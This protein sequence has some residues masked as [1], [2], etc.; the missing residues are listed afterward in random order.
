MFQNGYVLYKDDRGVHA[1]WDS[2]FC[3]RY[4]K[5]LQQVETKDKHVYPRDEIEI[6]SVHR[7]PITGYCDRNSM[8]TYHLV[9]N[10]SNISKSYC[11]NQVFGFAM[12]ASGSYGNRLTTEKGKQELFE[13]MYE[14]LYASYE[15]KLCM[16]QV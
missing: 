15:G 3:S 14:L 8:S 4:S 9:S 7:A 1:L 2:M 6:A 10:I 5:E 12:P 11:T 16:K 13:I